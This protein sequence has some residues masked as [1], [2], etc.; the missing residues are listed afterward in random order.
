[1]PLSSHPQDLFDHKPERL[2]LTGYRCAMA[3]Y[4]HGDASC[5]DELWST[6]VDDG[7]LSFA[8]DI[9]G[10]LQYFV[11][12]L[13]PALNMGLNY[14]PRNCRRVC[15]KECLVLSLLSAAQHADATVQHGALVRLLG[16]DQAGNYDLMTQAALHFTEGLTRAQY[17]LLPVPM[18]VL[19]SFDSQPVCRQLCKQDIH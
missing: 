1:M 5:W 12:S 3:G 9:M 2:A 10:S 15:R 13:R 16:D 4:D 14:Y 17:H 11:R 7:G 19:L 18:A 8:C 6:Y